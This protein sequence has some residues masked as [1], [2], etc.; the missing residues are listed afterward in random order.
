MRQLV[1]SSLS[2]SEIA[3]SAGFNNLSHF[4]HTFR[5]IHGCAP[6][7]FQKSRPEHNRKTH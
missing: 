7:T 3:F 1:E 6:G 4:N 5:A 2:I